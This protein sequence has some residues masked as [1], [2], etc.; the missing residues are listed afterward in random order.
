MGLDEYLE[1]FAVT[2]ARQPGQKSAATLREVFREQRRS[3]RWVFRYVNQR[4]ED[5]VINDSEFQQK[6]TEFFWSF[7]Y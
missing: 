3:P 7:C 6:L 1:Y 4:V 5:Q 2:L